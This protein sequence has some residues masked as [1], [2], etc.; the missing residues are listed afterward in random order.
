M[1]TLLIKYT[2][3]IITALHFLGRYYFVIW[4]NNLQWTIHFLFEGKHKSNLRGSSVHVVRHF[5]IPE[6]TDRF[7]PTAFPLSLAEEQV[8]GSFCSGSEQSVSVA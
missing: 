1:T 5:C 8:L 3:K 7:V 2:V 6:C 4:Q